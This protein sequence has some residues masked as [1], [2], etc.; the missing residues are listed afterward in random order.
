MVTFQFKLTENTDVKWETIL[1]KSK[2]YVQVPCGIL[3]DGSKEAFITLLEYAEEE[4]H[5]SHVIVCFTKNRAD[6]ATLVRTFM[7][8]GFMTLAPGHELVPA[9]SSED[10]LYMAYMIE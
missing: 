8:L 6:R 3:P 2:L 1:W 5:C 9:N 10:K 7:F 4:L